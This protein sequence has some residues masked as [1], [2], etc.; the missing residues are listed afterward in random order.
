MGAW[1]WVRVW[2]RVYGCV[3]RSCVCMCA[4]FGARVCVC[5][6]EYGCVCMGSWVG[7]RVSVCGRVLAR[8]GACVWGHMSVWV[9]ASVCGCMCV[10]R[11]P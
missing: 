8:V 7:A 5:G 9:R 3:C 4:Y 10:V 1:V 6:C 2:V 11:H